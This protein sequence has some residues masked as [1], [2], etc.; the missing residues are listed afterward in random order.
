MGVPAVNV[1]ECCGLVQ[2]FVAFR[3]ELTDWMAP[4]RALLS[5]KADFIC[6]SSQASAFSKVIHELSSP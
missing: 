1:P 4:I 2:Q 5:P 3:P 6:T